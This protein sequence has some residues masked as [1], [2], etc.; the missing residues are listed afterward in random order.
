MGE[1]ET[2]TLPRTVEYTMRHSDRRGSDDE[3]MLTCLPRRRW[4][5]QL[6]SSQ[7]TS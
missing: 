4:P 2:I 3:P 6:P 1:T 7:T 5:H